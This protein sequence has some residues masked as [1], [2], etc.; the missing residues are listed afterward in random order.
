MNAD[1]PAVTTGMPERPR[2]AGTVRERRDTTDGSARS[3]LGAPIRL[4]LCLALAALLS[5]RVAAAEDTAL[6]PGVVARVHGREI[7]E[8]DLLDRLVRRWGGTERGKQTLD[9]L[10]DDTCVANEAAKRGVTVTDEEVAEYVKKVDE[11]IR[12]Q[13]GNSRSI[14]DVYKEQH[15]DAAEFARIA[16]EYLKRQKMACEDMGA[17]PGEEITEARLKLWLSSLR[18]RARVKLTD[19]PEGALAVVGDTVI[20][21]AHFARALK[22]QLPEEAWLGARADLVLEA[23]AAHALDEAGIS[24]TDADVDA[25]IAKLRKRFSQDPRVKNTG[26]TFDDFLRQSRGTSEAELRADP[27]FRMRIG[28]EHLL[29]RNVSDEDVRKQWET[30]RDAYGER[31]LVRQVYVAGQD[32]GGKFQMRTFKEAFE[33]ALRAKAAILEKSGALGTANS[34]RASLPDALT[35]VAKQFE[36]DPKARQAAGEPVAW[37]RANL[38]GDDALAKAV[39]EGEAGTLIG[40]VR[41]RVGYHL[42]LVE[43]R[44]PAPSFDDVKDTVRDDLLRRAVATFQLSMKADPE[45]VIATK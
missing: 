37:T 29:A 1:A 24:V 33:L 9:L 4:L 25:D 31:A 28:L 26:L 43:E 23:A 8:T 15:S 40:P 7:K 20:D 12:K 44:R 38:L 13:T 11:T 36:E 30:N 42:L 21:R 39:F 6:P 16:R 5:H 14:E 17:K 10:V 34:G 3:V 32:E 19:L 22:D 2:R 45:V 27:G 18:R 35:A 41:S